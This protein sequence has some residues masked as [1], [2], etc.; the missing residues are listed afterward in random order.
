MPSGEAGLSAVLGPSRARLLC[1]LVVVLFLSALGF[2]LERANRR[3]SLDERLDGREA[4]APNYRHIWFAHDPA[5]LKGGQ[6]GDNVC[7]FGM[8]LRPAHDNWQTIC[9]RDDDGDGLTN[10]EELGDPCCLWTP[11]DM[12]KSFDLGT[13]QEYRRWDITH[14]GRPDKVLPSKTSVEPLNCSTYDAGL[15]ARQFREFYFKKVDGPREDVP[16]VP[17]KLVALAFLLGLLGHWFHCKGLGADICPLLFPWKSSLS[18]Q[19]S[20]LTCIASY[21]YMDMTSGI[22][23]LILDY[24]PHWLPIIGPL[25]KGFQYHHADPTAI[26]R[27]SW[28]AYVSH[29]HLLCPLVFVVVVL[30]K[31]S[32]VQRLFWFWGAVFVHVF[33]TAHRWAHFQPESLPSVVQSLQAAGMLLTHERHMSHH[34]D[35]ESQFTILSGHSDILLDGASRVIPPWRYDLWIVLGVAWFVMP[36]AIDLRF[37]SVFESW[38]FETCLP[39]PKKTDVELSEFESCDTEAANMSR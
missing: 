30:G 27:I 21:V 9:S 7:A 13:Q 34:Q 37:R 1:T 23:H 18:P 22:V 32:R 31:A 24:A 35:L 28:Y 26:V 33:Q 10:G 38:D 17:A 29:V 36:I 2:V 3:A 16:L 6:T 39:H 25:A 11:G 8:Q 15:Y 20:F 14:P 5:F 4:W 12:G 19:V